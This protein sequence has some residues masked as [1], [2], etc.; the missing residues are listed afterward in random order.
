MTWY[1]FFY[2]YYRT[3]V[4]FFTWASLTS[5]SFLHT[6]PGMHDCSRDRDSYHTLS[7]PRQRVTLWPYFFFHTRTNQ[8]WL[9]KNFLLSGGKCF[10]CRCLHMLAIIY[11]CTL[12]LC[13]Y[14]VELH[15]ICLKFSKCRQQY[16]FHLFLSKLYLWYVC[17]GMTTFMRK[18]W[19][20][21]R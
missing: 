4:V 1:T 16:P 2:I 19:K 18:V 8:M 6:S 3:R 17:L 12:C 21:I 11:K 5:E 10:T 13:K 9:H 7:A 14:L 15:M 20:I